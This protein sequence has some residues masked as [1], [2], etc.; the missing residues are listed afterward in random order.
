VRRLVSHVADPGAARA[1]CGKT[2]SGKRPLRLFGRW[3]LVCP[4]CMDA[5]L[6]M[7]SAEHA[8]L[9]D[10]HNIAV[11]TINHAVHA[12]NDGLAQYRATETEAADD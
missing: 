10:L 8:N 11:D 7:P 4:G 12:L 2:L 3:W 1:L 6:T 9:L 5:G